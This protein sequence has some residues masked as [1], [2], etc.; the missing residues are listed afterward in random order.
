MFSRG[1]G[2]AS[3]VGAI[4]SVCTFN[5]KDFMIGL[6]EIISLLTAECIA[7]GS[8]PSK[9]TQ[10]TFLLEGA[11]FVDLLAVKGLAEV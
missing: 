7:L 3:S 2:A 10:S 1:T 11:F 5:E 8:G 4:I 9:A 6:Q